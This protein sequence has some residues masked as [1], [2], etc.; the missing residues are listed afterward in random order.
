MTAV[1]NPILKKL[2]GK[3]KIQ[4]FH[5]VAHI[6]VRRPFTTMHGLLQLYVHLTTAGFC[7]YTTGK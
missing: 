7:T 3:K 4:C 5:L 6:T 2:A 1:E